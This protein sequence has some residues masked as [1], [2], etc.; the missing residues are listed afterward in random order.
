MDLSF[1]RKD[2]ERLYVD[3]CNIY[4]YQEVLDPE[5]GITEHQEVLVHENVPCKLSHKSVSQAGEGI[6]APINLVSS[7]TLSPDITVPAGSKIIVTR[8]GIATAYRN[9]GEPAIHIN[10]QKIVLELFEDYA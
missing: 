3:R 2:L 10:H 5:T 4:E 6:V 7:L 1:A 8:N 9:S